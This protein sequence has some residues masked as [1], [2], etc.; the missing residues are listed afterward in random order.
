MEAPEDKRQELWATVR[1]T[2]NGDGTPYFQFVE[3]TRKITADD[4]IVATV[5]LRSK[6]KSS[7]AILVDWGDAPGQQCSLSD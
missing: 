7:A 5:H 4:S 6:S 3:G 2:N 1:V